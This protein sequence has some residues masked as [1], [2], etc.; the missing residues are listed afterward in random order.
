MRWCSIGYRAQE[1]QSVS[2]RIFGDLDAPEADQFNSAGLEPLYLALT[3]EGLLLEMGQGF[4][5]HF[6]PLT[7][8]AYKIDVADI[9]DLRTEGDRAIAGV[10]LASLTCTWSFETAS[11]RFLPSWTL[12]RDLIAKGAA[13]ILAPSFATGARP[14]MANLVL[15]RWGPTPPHQILVVDPKARLSS[16]R[17]PVPE[18]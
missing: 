5:H 16:E 1:A 7:I 8:Q 12:A 14:S 17:W 6:N 2:A 3:L 15:W 11:R 9:I 4:G 13:G 18:P 10:E